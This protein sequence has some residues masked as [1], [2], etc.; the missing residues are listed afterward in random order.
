MADSDF[1]PDL[2]CWHTA[3][4]A[5]VTKFMDGDMVALVSRNPFHWSGQLV[6]RVGD[7]TGQTGCESSD[8]DLGECRLFFRG[9]RVGSPVRMHG[10]QFGQVLGDGV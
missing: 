2:I 3:V 1:F 4:S 7:H 8:K 6:D 10:S 9:R 5:I